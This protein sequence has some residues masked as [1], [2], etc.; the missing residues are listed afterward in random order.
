LDKLGFD[1]T[2]Q[3]PLNIDEVNDEV[4]NYAI[5]AYNLGV[6]GN[7]ET[8]PYVNFGDK[9]S[10]IEVARFIVKT[11]NLKYVSD[12]DEHLKAYDDTYDLSINDQ[13]IAQLT[14]YYGYLKGEGNNFYPHNALNRA[15]L[16]II[17]KRILDAPKITLNDSNVKIDILTNY[18]KLTINNGVIKIND[19]QIATFTPKDADILVYVNGEK[20]NNL[21]NIDYATI[22]IIASKNGLKIGKTFNY[23]ANNIDSDDDGVADINDIEPYN[24]NIYTGDSDNDGIDDIDEFI[25]GTNPYLTDSDGDGISD[26][27]EGFEDTDGDGLIDALD[28]DSDNDGITD[29]EEIK[30]GLNPKDPSDATDTDNDK[31]PDVIDPDDDN[32]GISDEDEISNWLDPKNPQDADMDYDK[33]GLS[34]KDEINILGTDIRDKNYYYD[35]FEI[36]SEDKSIDTDLEGF[37]FFKHEAILGD[38]IQFSF[39]IE[40]K[41][42]NFKLI[43]IKKKDLIPEISF[44]I[45]NDRVDT[46]LIVTQE[47]ENKTIDLYARF[48]VGKKEI[49][50]PFKIKIYMKVMTK[51]IG[52]IAINSLP[53][54]VAVKDNIAYIASF[55]DAQ[56]KLY[57]IS[58]PKNIKYLKSFRIGEATIT[59][60]FIDNQRMYVALGSEGVAIVDVTDTKN[61]KLVKTKETGREYWDIFGQSLR[62]GD[63]SIDNEYVYAVD[64]KAGKLDIFDDQLNIV[65]TIDIPKSQRSIRVYAESNEYISYTKGGIITGRLV[66]VYGDEIGVKIYYFAGN[67]FDKMYD[68]YE[69]S[70]LSVSGISSYNHIAHITS[71]S[72]RK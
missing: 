13:V 34:N 36:L 1:G 30:Y 9:I 22:D 33:D 26:K 46:T 37:S 64:N 48:Q 61:P 70:N 29:K 14:N 62:D 60:L 66:F 43:G 16:A 5:V 21:E 58:D 50:I 25:Y 55:D 10:R 67:K 6:F 7:V 40:S 65:K 15:Q 42:N 54:A 18:P 44:S 28:T 47:M 56:I 68:V 35:F 17:A 24:S 53:M 63:Y 38:T 3:K 32:D 45:N 11:L 23:F 4:K 20:T 41:N 59:D 12:L 69:N 49:E 57:D 72:K 27:E 39:N 8:T 2:I 71:K 51:P 31:I 52:E 19:M